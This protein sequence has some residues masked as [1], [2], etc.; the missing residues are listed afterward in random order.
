MSESEVI[1]ITA[2]EA[3]LPITANG[4]RITNLHSPGDSTNHRYQH[5]SDNSTDHGYP[6]GLLP[7]PVW[8]WRRK[9]MPQFLPL[10]RS[11]QGMGLQ[12][13]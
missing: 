11:Y 2:K 10:E 8:P 9:S 6:H 5:A 3:S 4:S 12:D 1:D 7:S 13:C